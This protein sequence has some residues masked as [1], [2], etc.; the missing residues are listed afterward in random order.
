MATLTIRTA[1][2]GNPNAAGG[3]A[4][5]GWI[6]PVGRGTANGS[7]YAN[8]APLSSLAAMIAAG[9]PGYYNILADEGSY[10]I[11]GA[12]PAVTIANAG[13]ATAQ[14]PV[15]IRGI[16]AAGAAAKATMQG[17]RTAW[18]L[19]ADPETVT[20]TRAWTDGG[21][22]VFR[23][24]A[25]AASYITFRDLHFKDIGGHT[26]AGAVSSGG[27]TTIYVSA[28]PVAGIRIVDCT[29]LNVRRLFDTATAVSV[30]GLSIESTTVTG[31]S[32]NCVRVRGDTD[33]IT[34][35]DCVFDSGR[36][37]G[38]NFAQG[39]QVEETAH[40][41]V[42]SRCTFKG[43]HD[44]VNAYANGDGISAE[45]TTY[46]LAVYDSTFEGNTDGGVDIKCATGSVWFER[47]T[48]TGNKRNI[49]VWQRTNATPMFFVDCTSASPYERAGTS[50]NPCHVFLTGGTTS[51]DPGAIITLTRPILTG[52]VTQG[53]S[54]QPVGNRVRIEGHNALCTLQDLLIDNPSGVSD[55]LTQGT[56]SVVEIETPPDP[57][58][59]YALL[60]GADGLYLR[61]AD[62]AYLHALV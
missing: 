52:F 37:D 35:A 26:S 49:R 51:G 38:D 24:S 55:T 11:S 9:G 3:L 42:V 8:A 7:S 31:F 6:A 5:K 48:F 59:G 30:P 58:A 10:T 27:S 17:T 61:G 1:R 39:L 41:I 2:R 46:N 33:G 62:G 56:S 36:Q 19:P 15:V 16:T 53:V 12:S 54:G 50:G 22:E 23:L 60:T 32:K 14:K 44:T 40:N 43:C 4:V 47:C 45:A 34:L 13:G 18:T 57:P 29:A 25:S 21:A 20:D 28:G